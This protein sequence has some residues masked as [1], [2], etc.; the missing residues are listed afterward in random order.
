[1]AVPWLAL[2]AAVS[3]S[4]A[5]VRQESVDA[6]LQVEWKTKTVYLP[7]EKVVFGGGVKTTYGVTVMKSDT[8]TV[9]YGEG[10]ASGIAEGNVLVEDP[11]GTIEASRIQFDWKKRTGE[12]NNVTVRVDPMVMEAQRLQVQPGRWELTNVKIMEC[13]VKPAFYTM[14]SPSVVIEPG[15]RTT[16]RKVN[17]ALF[18]QKVLTLR[19]HEVSLDRKSEGLRLP[20][21]SI[22]RG[23]GLGV[24]WQSGVPLTNSTYT[25]FRFTS[26]PRRRPSSSLHISRSFLDPDEVR[27]LLTPRSDLSELFSFGYLENINVEAPEN[28]REYLSHDRATVSASSVWNSGVSGRTS[29]DSVNKPW[30]LAL[31]VGGAPG[32][33]SQKHQLRLQE[34]EQIGTRRETRAVAISSVR[35]P[36]LKLGPNITAAARGDGRW[37]FNE[38]GQAK[39][40]RVIGEV[41]WRPSIRFRLGVGY[42]VGSNEG[43]FAFDFDRLE[44][45]RVLHVR[46]DMLLGPTRLFLLGKYDTERSDWYDLQIA[47]YQLAGCFEP[48]VVYRKDVGSLGF[49]LRL[50]VFE[51]FERLKDRIPKRLPGNRIEG[52]PAGSGPRH[53]DAPDWWAP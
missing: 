16:A 26:F 39:W 46:T 7:E 5:E 23:A 33:F 53:P 21:V 48:Y 43:R 35:T 13:G 18:G 14:W 12:A 25:D 2:P 36:D 9:F 20:S 30:D 24:T 34:I 15:K 29:R 19:R 10:A 45:A 11:E 50:R 1:M 40:G 47:F 38:N 49:G 44:R 28:E 27:T 8:L 37:F 4:V 51:A 6:L 31:E 42:S 52:R 17:L 22:R 41:I 32:G 3:F